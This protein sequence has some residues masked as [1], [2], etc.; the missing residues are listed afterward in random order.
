MRRRRG[1][2]LKQSS[3]GLKERSWYSKLKYEALNRTLW[4]IRL[5]SGY[6]HLVRQPTKLLSTKCQHVYPDSKHVVLENFLFSWKP[7]TLPFWPTVTFLYSLKQHATK[8]H[9]DGDVEHH[10]SPSALQKDR[11]VKFIHFEVAQC[12]ILDKKFGG[13]QGLPGHFET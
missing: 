13:P 1:K 2:R 12:N 7:E 3:V 5:G 8:T 10:G 4:R 11:G 9:K 6:G